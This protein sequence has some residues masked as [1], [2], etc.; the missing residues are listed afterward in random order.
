MKFV[1]CLLAAL[2]ALSAMGQQT[3]KPA[4]DG[5]NNLSFME[6]EWAGQ[7]NFNTQNGKPMV[8]DA[9]DNI[10]VCIEGKFVCEMLSTTLPNRKPTDTRH[11][12]SFDKQ[13]GKYTAWWFNDTSVRPMELTGDV[14]GNKLVLT[15]DASAPG[16]V[17]RATYELTPENKLTFLLEMKQ[18][19]S[20]TKLFLTTY[21]KK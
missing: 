6:G 5:L 17:L 12:I 9:T 11:F 15:S 18:G 19:D 20:W 4:A 3:P 1:V 2:G 16:P 13:T 10:A 14:S 8:G 21:A 7:Q